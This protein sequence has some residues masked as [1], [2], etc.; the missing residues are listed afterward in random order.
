[1]K[2]HELADNI[3]YME[4]ALPRAAEFIQQIEHNNTNPEINEVIPPWESWSDGYPVRVSE[5]E[6]VQVIPDT[7]DAHRGDA[8]HI[9]WDLTVNGGNGFWPRRKISNDHTPAHSMAYEIISLI[10]DD[11]I[12]AVSAWAEMTNNEMPEYVSRNYCIRRYRT[13]AAMGMH[14]D[15]NVDNPETTMDWTA[16]LYLNDDYG[17]GEIAFDNSDIS[18]KPSAGSIL[19][20]PCLAAHECKVITSGRKYYV[21]MFM[22]TKTKLNTSLG[23]PYESL[24]RAIKEYNKK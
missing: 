14:I 24:N 8:K 15:R 10:E 12:S 7:D 13:G 1:M 11:Y 16:L 3:I 23:E 4:D 22:H 19:F 6:W 5:T 21:F 18:L 17:G 20:L 2:I 9:D